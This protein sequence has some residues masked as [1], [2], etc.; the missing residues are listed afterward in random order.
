MPVVSMSHSSA[1]ADEYGN[2]YST[3]GAGLDVEVECGTLVTGLHRD[4]TEFAQEEP[5]HRVCTEFV[6]SCITNSVLSYKV[7]ANLLLVVLWRV[8]E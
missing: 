1:F 4:C 8:G 7:S 5:L 3:S 6:A 2:V